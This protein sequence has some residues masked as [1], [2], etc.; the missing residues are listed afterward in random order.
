MEDRELYRAI[1]LVTK[2]D[3]AELGYGEFDSLLDELKK[4]VGG[5]PD[6]AK[7]I[8]DAMELAEHSTYD[9]IASW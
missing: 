2:L 6:R 8:D 4:I 3:C 5:C 7:Q 1:V 9:Q